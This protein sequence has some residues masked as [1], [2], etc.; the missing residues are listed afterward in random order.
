MGGRRRRLVKLAEL[1][2][3]CSG[4]RPSAVS[5]PMGRYQ[6]LQLRGRRCQYSSSQRSDMSRVKVK[7]DCFASIGQVGIGK[8]GD[9]YYT[10]LVEST[11][12]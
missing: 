3:E 1:G 6:G 9:Y 12:I 7:I 10:K 11:Y 2:E 4:D 5:C 8:A